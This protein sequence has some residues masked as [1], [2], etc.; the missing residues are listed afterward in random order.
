MTKGF[1]SEWERTFRRKNENDLKDT[2]GFEAK[3]WG[4][5]CAW[6]KAQSYLGWLPWLV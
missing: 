6:H 4:I 5:I 1:L 3:K 2:N